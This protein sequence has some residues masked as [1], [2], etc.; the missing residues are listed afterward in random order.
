M[1]TQT[2]APE[3]RPKTLSP[4]IELHPNL[5]TQLAGI[6]EQAEKPKETKSAQVSS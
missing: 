3:N 6:V 4:E 1:L 5:V 2:Q